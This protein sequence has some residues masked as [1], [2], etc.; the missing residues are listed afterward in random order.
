MQKILPN[1]ILLLP[2]TVTLSEVIQNT[3]NGVLVQAVLIFTEAGHK[4]TQVLLTSHV[5]LR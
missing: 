3:H 1:H 5:E 2:L 4:G